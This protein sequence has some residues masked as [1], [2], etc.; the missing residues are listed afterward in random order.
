[1][2]LTNVEFYYGTTLIGSD[3]TSPY[4][5]SWN[6]TG[7]PTAATTLTSKAYDAAGNNATST[8]VNVT[9]NNVAGPPDLTATYSTTYLTPACP[10]GGKSCDTGASLINGRAR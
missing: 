7:V 9:V 8:A 3:T 1:M 5:V 6:T 2:A 4:S 10:A